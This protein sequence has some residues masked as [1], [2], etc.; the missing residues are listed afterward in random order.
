MLA[1]RHCGFIVRPGNFSLTVDVLANTALYLRGKTALKKRAVVLPHFDLTKI[2]NNIPEI[3]HHIRLR[4]QQLDLTPLRDAARSYTVIRKELTRLEQEIG[5][6][7]AQRKKKT[8][9]FLEVQI[10]QLINV[11]RDVK[12]D[13]NKIDAVC[14]PLLLQI[15]NTPLCKCVK[16]IARLCRTYVPP[17]KF[18]FQPKDHID[19][20]GHKLQFMNQTL[21]YLL[22][23][24]AG[25]E[26]KICSMFIDK[27]D[28]SGR[29]PV[30]GPDFVLD[31]IVEGAAT[32]NSIVI[33]EQNSGGHRT[34]LTGGSSLEAFCAQLM[35]REISVGTTRQYC[36]ARFYQE[37]G[38]EESL[39]TLSQS[40]RV[41]AFTGSS[42]EVLSDV[43]ELLTLLAEL[44]GELNVP[45]RMR[46][47][48][49]PDLSFIEQLR[50]DLD[51]WSPVEEKWKVAAHVASHG[52][53]LS[54][55][56]HMVTEKEPMFTM[57][58]VCAD[59]HQV[60]AFLLENHQ[61]ADGSYTLPPSLTNSHPA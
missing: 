16:S 50:V 51:V 46:F 40:T 29:V 55:R 44:Y 18:S 39:Y 52:Q 37:G 25:L 28:A 36:S 60:V 14:A 30:S 23:D 33:E 61:N 38:T 54:S 41:T 21:C 4:G 47:V 32:N 17:R 48:G 1:L 8:N 9:E 6:L 42:S 22:E 24:L 26:Q 12:K 27:L 20:G 19:L 56:L 59:A 5:K 35:K 49:P 10:K 43:E 45:F 57:F 3:E 7:T 58:A 34:H 11:Q 2:V 53:F 13:F 15:P 31:T